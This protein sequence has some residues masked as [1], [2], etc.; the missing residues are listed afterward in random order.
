MPDRYAWQNRLF[1][2]TLDDGQR[3]LQQWYN[4]PE[5]LK[6]M[7]YLDQLQQAKNWLEEQW[8]QQRAAK[9]WLE[10]AWNQEKARR[11]QLE[12]QVGQLEQQAEQLRQQ[13]EQLQ[14][15]NPAFLAKQ[16]ARK[17][18]RVLAKRRKK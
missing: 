7:A 3:R 9:D 13:Y 6:S 14:R 1:R 12:Q 2:F 18:I 17:T 10:N 15:K 11:E 4:V 8:N 16:A 5:L